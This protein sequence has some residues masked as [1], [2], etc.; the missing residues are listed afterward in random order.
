MQRRQFIAGLGSAAAW[1]VVARAQQPALPVIGFLGYWDSPSR[2]TNVL[3]A[4]HQGLATTGFVEGRNVTIEYRWG[5]YQ[6]D[7]LLAL[8]RE[9]VRHRV[10]VIVAAGFG[11][12][13]VAAKAATSTIPIVFTFGG[14]PVSAGFV[15]SLSRPEGNVTG[16][17]TI[18]GDLGSK[19]LNLLRDLVP[20]ATTVAY[21]S[22]PN[23]GEREQ[24]LAA[25]RHLGRQL[26]ILEIRG[27]G[28]YEGAFATLLNRQ[29][30]ALIVGTTPLDD[31]KIVELAAQYKIPT[32]YQRREQTEAG[33]LISYGAD[34]ADIYRQA[35]IYTGRILKGEKPADLP[36]I[37]PTKFNLIINLKTAKALGL[38]VP[39]T[40]LATA[41]ELIE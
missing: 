34:F 32:M 28:D 22:R 3:V 16:A 31:K 14:D 5:N 23:R 25:A 24:L 36:V 37:L 8:A 19:R 33:G 17:S 39:E 1:P 15:A 38:T 26:V 41:D 20:Q 18:S 21:L 9:L 7:R 2:I 12:P 35:G 4:F 40:L 11:P 10:A 13:V 29:A 27:S 6:F 30:G